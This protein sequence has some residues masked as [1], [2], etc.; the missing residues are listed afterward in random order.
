MLRNLLG[1]ERILLGN[2]AKIVDQCGSSR[3]AF[4]LKLSEGATICATV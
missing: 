1:P 2:M 3:H 4:T